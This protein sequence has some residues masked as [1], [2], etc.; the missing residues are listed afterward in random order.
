MSKYKVPVQSLIDHIKTAVDVDDWAKEMAEELLKP[1]EAMN[2]N[3]TDYNLL[4]K[5]LDAIER[6]IKYYDRK[7]FE[8]AV[9]KTEAA[10]VIRQ[11]IAAIKA[12]YL[13]E[14]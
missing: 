7:F 14:D 8:T 10:G 5:Q 3:K 9:N 13:A 1:L 2:E 12:A 11:A 6:Y 4:I